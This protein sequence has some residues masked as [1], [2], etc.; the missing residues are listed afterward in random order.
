VWRIAQGD[1]NLHFACILPESF[2]YPKELGASEHP[3]R[4]GQQKMAMALI[5]YVSTITGWDI[6]HDM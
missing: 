1:K 6:R 2:A 3:N 4:V 5:P